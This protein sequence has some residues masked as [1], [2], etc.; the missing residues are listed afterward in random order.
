M[1]GDIMSGW[2]DPTWK[3]GGLYT[4]PELQNIGVAITPPQQREEPT[5]M[6]DERN[7]HLYAA[8]DALDL[9][10]TSSN[11]VI[12]NRWLEAALGHILD[13]MPPLSQGEAK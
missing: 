12:C 2:D 3:A 11:D 13:A 8:K 1:A 10:L 4:F 6:G 9:A 7:K 5:M